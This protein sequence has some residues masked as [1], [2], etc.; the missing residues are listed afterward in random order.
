[1]C[2]QNPWVSLVW[3]SLS[4]LDFFDMEFANCDMFP[5]AIGDQPYLWQ[6]GSLNGN[7]VP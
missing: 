6:C 5:W 2:S 4:F 1:M 3:I 7:S